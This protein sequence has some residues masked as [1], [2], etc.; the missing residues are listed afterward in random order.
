MLLSILILICINTL[1]LGVEEVLDMGARR[2]L[3]ARV[4]T[5]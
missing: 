1:V 2:E 4:E 5:L 3:Q